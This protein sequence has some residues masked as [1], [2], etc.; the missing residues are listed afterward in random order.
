MIKLY[1]IHVGKAMKKILLLGQVTISSTSGSMPLKT[2]FNMHM[3]D[4]F[5]L[6]GGTYTL[7]ICNDQTL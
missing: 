7:V 3:P 4:E 2:I 6:D 5:R 1:N